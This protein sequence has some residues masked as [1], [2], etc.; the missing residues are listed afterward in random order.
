MA[1][2]KHGLVNIT[3]DESHGVDEDPGEFLVPASPR[4]FQAIQHVLQVQ[5]LA[6]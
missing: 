6:V 1:L 4:L 2:E 3:P 5:N